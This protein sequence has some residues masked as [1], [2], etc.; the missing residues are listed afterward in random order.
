[1]GY[2]Q[3]VLCSGNNPKHKL[4]HRLVAQA[5]IDNPENKGCVD[6]INTDRG[7]NRVENLQWVTHTENNL[8]PITRKRLSECKTLARMSEETKRKRSRAVVQ[9]D[10]DGNCLAEFW[11][12][13][14]AQ[15]QTG[16]LYVGISTCCRG[17]T[18]TAGGYIWKYKDNRYGKG[19]D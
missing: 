19:I 9:Y 1:M 5:F 7:D 6:H 17:I 10:K 18:R 11:G 15:R 16:V 12:L 2:V 14:E 4:V 13:K 3:V 8:N